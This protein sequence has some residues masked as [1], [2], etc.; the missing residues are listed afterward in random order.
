MEW[1]GYNDPVGMVIGL[2]LPVIATI[3]I[4]FYFYQNEVKSL[5]MSLRAMFMLV[6]TIACGI[7]L[8]IWAYPWLF[9]GGGP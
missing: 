1:Y 9:G 2:M 5:R 4:W 7:K 3:S 6:L 8:S